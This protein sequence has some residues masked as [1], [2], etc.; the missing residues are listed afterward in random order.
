MKK[1][2]ELRKPIMINNKEVKELTY[3]FDEITCD[4]FTMASAYADSKGFRANQN[5][6]PSMA[7]IEQNANIHMYIGM[8]AIIA[9]NR[10]IDITDLER[11]KGYDLVAIAGIGRNFILGK[12]EEP[13]SQSDSEKQSEATLESTTQESEK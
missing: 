2:F 3:D 6:R 11:I 12:S 13:S 10:D 7:V 1:T 5:G 4:D 9:V 8:M